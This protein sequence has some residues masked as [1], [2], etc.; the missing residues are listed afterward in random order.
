MTS[1]KTTVITAGPVAYSSNSLTTNAPPY[2]HIAP[3]LKAI[4]NVHT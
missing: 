1:R 4:T 3:V 2:K